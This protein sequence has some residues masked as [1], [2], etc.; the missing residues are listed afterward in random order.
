MRIYID[1]R[2][3][4]P[5]RAPGIPGGAQ[6]DLTRGTQTRLE[7]QFLADGRTPV[8]LEGVDGLTFVAKPRGQ[9]DVAPLIRCVDWEFP[10]TADTDP[11]YAAHPNLN[12]AE[13]NAL[14]FIDGDPS[15]DVAKVELQAALSWQRGSGPKSS[16][17][18]F[19]VSVFNDLD[20]EGD[21]TPDPLD[22]PDAYE[23]RSAK[24]QPMGY[25][26]LDGAGLLPESYLP[27]LSDQFAPLVGGLVP[28][29]VLPEEV[30]GTGGSP[31]EPAVSAYDLHFDF[32]SGAVAN[33]AVALAVS[34]RALEIATGPH[35]AYCSS[36]AAPVTFTVKGNGDVLGSIEVIAAGTA[37]F[38]FAETIELNWTQN[39]ITIE[40]PTSGANGIEGL[41][42]TLR[43][44]ATSAIQV[45]PPEPTLPDVDPINP[46]DLWPSLWLDAQDTSK[47]FTTEGGSTQASVGDPVGRWED[48]SGWP[49]VNFTQDSDSD[50]PVL[51]SEDGF[52]WL[53]CNGKG[54]NNWG[55]GGLI[56]M[57]TSIITVIA[58]FK[59]VP[60]ASGSILKV[61][62]TISD[63]P[64]EDDYDLVG[65]A[66]ASGAG[67]YQVTMR[68]VRRYPQ[69]VLSA[70][71]DASTAPVAI[72]V[73]RHNFSYD[74]EGDTVTLRL[75]GTTF[76]T[77]SQGDDGGF[78][79][80]SE[81]GYIG[82]TAE[83]GD[84]SKI[85]EI[86]VFGPLSSEEIAGVEAYLSN[87]YN[88]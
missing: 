20:R 34:S 10:H 28:L 43:A 31:V 16:T 5:M 73:L 69:P 75:N 14:F 47:L 2:T 25:A 38:N 82:N 53:D 87:K 63:P 6:H 70:T 68:T 50:R 30:G 18:P 13:L 22:P 4:R 41:R 12:T 54:L 36:A 66:H 57:E 23:R 71:S 65:I 49:Y 67:D 76:A 83:S 64:P 7:V 86:L 3:N 26:P 24:G 59:P 19:A 21:V 80:S 39:L 15:N 88:L 42:I 79:G 77:L 40:A 32:G 44:V 1:L 11:V 58:V 84:R 35:I 48:K 52:N 45:E 46:Q 72:A 55:F 56:N 74:G 85:A 27:D 62:M 17:L 51:I 8:V 78:P 81:F 61:P 37:L 33:N 60:D 29:S 9:F